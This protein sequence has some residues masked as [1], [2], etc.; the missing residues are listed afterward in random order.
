MS[1]PGFVLEVDE[2]TP[3]L[4]MLAG[5]DL[6]LE[7]LGLG[8]QVAYPADPVASVDPVGLIDAALES[9]VG[10]ESLPSLLGPATRLT[11][12]VRDHHRPE[13][14]MRFDVRRSIVE[15]VL[16]HAA[17][18]GVDDV[19]IVIATGLNR[20]WSAP[21][22]SAILGDRVAT[23]FIPDGLIGSH[24]VSSADLVEV[25]QVGGLPVK[26]NKRVAESDVVVSVGVV[27]DHSQ[28]CDFALGLT[29]VETINRLDGLGRDEATSREIVDLV[30]SAVPAFAVTA[31]LGQP[32]LGTSL[33]FLNKREW[34][35]RLPEQLAFAGARQLGS[36][37]PKQS[38]QRLFGTP[39]ADYAIGDMIGG[40]PTAVREQARQAWT[41]ANSVALPGQADV[42]AM[43]VWGGSFDRGNPVGSPLNAARNALV[44]QAGSHLG[45]PL[46]RDGGVVVARHPLARNFSNRTQSAAAD[47][48]ATVLPETL[49]PEEIAQRFEEGAMHDPWYLNLYREHYA[50]HPLKVFHTWYRIREATAGLGDVIWVGADRHSAALM[51]HRAAT[52][53]ADALEIASNTV[54]SHPSVTHLHGPGRLLGVIT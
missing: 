52:T 28:G 47:L 39:V 20:R 54:G 50:D 27:H 34:E 23:S 6:R 29:D 38:A 1:R 5:A 16:E 26:L 35:W 4:L 21:E 13:P 41:A 49:D 8:T 18:A 10:A 22:I 7:R 19:Q 2:R 37:L 33:S 42:L 53:F 11:I 51:G 31:V 25:G 32:L 36:L 46:V 9:P 44:T 48:F 14:R 15:R 3:P 45:T 17:R 40:D 43:S 24:D 12:V 30:G